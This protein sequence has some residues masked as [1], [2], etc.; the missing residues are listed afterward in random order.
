VDRNVP[1]SIARL[2][3]IILASVGKIGR[4]VSVGEAVVEVRHSE[5]RRNEEIAVVTVE[6][7]RLG[8]RSPTKL[9]YQNSH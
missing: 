2:D 7:K 1:G 4:K 3:L 9:I 8:F 6:N 5:I